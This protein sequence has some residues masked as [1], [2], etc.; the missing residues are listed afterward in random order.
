MGRRQLRFTDNADHFQRIGVKHRKLIVAVIGHATVTRI[1]RNARSC[2]RLKEASL[3]GTNSN[4]SAQAGV[5]R[6]R[7]RTARYRI[8]SLCFIGI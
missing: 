8:H 3:A 6:V 7:A 2:G 5:T 4:L 1:R